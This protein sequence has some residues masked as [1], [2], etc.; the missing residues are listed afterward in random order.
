MCR[1][2]VK[3]PSG[4]HDKSNVWIERLIAYLQQVEELKRLHLE[5]KAPVDEQQHQIGVLGR[6]DHAV[7]VRRAFHKR[8]AALLAYRG[9]MGQKCWLTG[10]AESQQRRREDNGFQHLVVVSY[11]K[12]K[13]I[14]LTGPHSFPRPSSPPPHLPPP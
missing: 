11:G 14:A 1:A 5:A 7:E 9:N 8:D 10:S 13:Q 4:G 12:T 2:N 3:S 6:I